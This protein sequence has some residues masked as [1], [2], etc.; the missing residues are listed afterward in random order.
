MSLTK[1]F[2]TTVLERAQNDKQ[3]RRAMLVDAV[4]ELLSGDIEVG[5][6]MLRD[7]INATIS[8][9]PLAKQLHKNS[10]S[11]QRM[12]GVA[13]NPTTK[14]LLAVLHILQQSEGITLQVNVNKSLR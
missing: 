9:E 8:F 13:G 12:F 11:V 10:K 6:S 2:K 7:Y 14:S 3:F 4:N 1:H 5:K